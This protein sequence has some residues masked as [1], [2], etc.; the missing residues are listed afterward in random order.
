MRFVTK[1][2]FDFNTAGV[3]R[4]V[5]PLAKSLVRMATQ[6]ETIISHH[7]QGVET[8]NQAQ[9]GDYIISSAQHDG[10]YVVS[11][12]RFAELYEA[13]PFDPRFYRAT[14]TRKALLVLEP[15]RFQANWGAEQNLPAGGMVIEAGEGIYGIDPFSFIRK[16]GRV[17]DSRSDNPVFT[18]LSDSLE[19]Q[20]AEAEKR[21]LINH[22]HDIDLRLQNQALFSG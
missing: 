10:S 4:K 20:R 12:H 22:L 7:S 21:F 8:T 15:V 18:R 14:E 6:I 9:V 5:E 3:Y 13:D 17:D 1:D 2:D 16:Y 19:W 11:A